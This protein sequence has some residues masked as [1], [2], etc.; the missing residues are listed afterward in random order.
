MQ[1]LAG[2]HEHPPV[3]GGDGLIDRQLGRPELGAVGDLARDQH[4]RAQ[5]QEHASIGDDRAGRSAPH[6]SSPTI[7]WCSETSERAGGGASGPCPSA[8]GASA[9]GR[10]AAARRGDVEP[11]WTAAIDGQRPTRS[12]V[13]PAS[14]SASTIRALNLQ[15]MVVP[16]KC[17]PYNSA[18]P[19]T[20]QTIIVLDFG[21]Q[22]TQLI[23]RRLRELSVY[24]E[25]LPFDT[26]LAEIARAHAGRDDPVG[27][28]EERL[29][30]RR[31]ALRAGGV[32]RRR[33]GPRHLLRHA[34]DDRTRSAGKS[35]PAPHREF[36]L[37][38][39]SIA[40]R[41]PLFASIPVDAARV[42]EPRRL[43]QGGAGRLRGHRDQ[44]QRAGGGDGGTGP[45]LVRA[46]CSTPRSRT[47]ITALDILRNFA[48]DVCGCTGDWTMALVRRRGDR[49]GF[50]SRSG[51]GG[52]VCGLSGGVDSTVA[53]MI[54]HRAIGDRLTCI[55][56]DNGVMR[57]DEAA[58][59]Q[60]ALRAAA[61]AAASS[62]TPR[63]CSS[64]GSPESPIR[65]RSARSSGAAFIDVFEAEAQQAG[66]V[67]LPRHRARSILMSSRASR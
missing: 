4:A 45:P 7:S 5:R 57:Q 31:A 24:S 56:V 62:S 38:T 17:T 32:R 43:R 6:R 50:A 55:F 33:P 28:T 2:H 65:S 42:G 52:V 58:Q 47:P 44:R 20:H 26:P 11:D 25:I 16:A 27:R 40:P 39:I 34:A 30:D 14:I 51:T 64:I 29:G 22:F 10:V 8:S 35:P 46:R 63:G 67:R 9:S 61:A 41:A 66:L 23:A 13:P 59:I 18:L 48:F 1:P 60:H 12:A 54:V 21:S 15:D 36:G 37:A 53:A 49:R 19:V 3:V